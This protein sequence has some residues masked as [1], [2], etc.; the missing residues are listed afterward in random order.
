MLKQGILYIHNY[1]CLHYFL[2]NPFF[3]II[4]MMIIFYFKKHF[5]PSYVC[6]YW[7]FKCNILCLLML[8]FLVKIGIRCLW[9]E[10]ICH[11][12]GTRFCYRENNEGISANTP[13]IIK[14]FSRT[15]HH[16]IKEVRIYWCIH[17]G[18]FISEKK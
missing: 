18:H 10:Y 2:L 6:H 14:I 11:H 12:E 1:V 9:W 3:T 16:G 15:W 7:S 17:V 13:F 4:L 8:Y 5:F